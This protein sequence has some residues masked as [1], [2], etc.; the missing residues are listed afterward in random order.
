MALRPSAQGEA[1]F[2]R[3]PVPD[4]DL[5]SSHERH[6]MLEEFK[7]TLQHYKALTSFPFT[8]TAPPLPKFSGLPSSFNFFV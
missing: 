4:A 6:R 7:G 2:T 1:A 5:T 3:C 8:R